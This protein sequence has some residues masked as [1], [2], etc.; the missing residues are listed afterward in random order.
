MNGV[1]GGT[2]VIL[3]AATIAL[4]VALGMVVPQ[5]APMS[6]AVAVFSSLLFLD[7]EVSRLR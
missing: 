3:L 5:T 1:K 4:N 7:M 6:W 2:M